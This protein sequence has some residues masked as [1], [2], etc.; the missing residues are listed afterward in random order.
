MQD[1]LCHHHAEISLIPY[2]SGHSLFDWQRMKREKVLHRQIQPMKLATEA[3]A[4]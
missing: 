4:V 3:A 1:P 2:W